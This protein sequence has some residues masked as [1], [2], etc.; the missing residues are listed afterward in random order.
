MATLS[1]YRLSRA[2]GRQISP[3][4]RRVVAPSRSAGRSARGALLA[5]AATLFAASETRADPDGPAGRSIELTF[6]TEQRPP[7]SF[8]SAAGGTIVGR[9][10]DL[11]REMTDRLGWNVAFKSEAWSRSYALAMSRPDTCVFSAARI[12]GREAAFQWVGPLDWSNFA[13]VAPADS[14]IELGSLEDA[15]PYRI[16]V[17]TQDARELMLR[18][19]GGYKLDVAT[20][21]TLN[22][23]KL[24]AGRIDLWFTDLSSMHEAQRREGIAL[25]PVLV[26]DPE[27]LYLA[28]NRATPDWAIRAMNETLVALEN[29]GARKRIQSK[30]LK[31]PL[32]GSP[33]AR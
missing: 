17:Y 3:R 20:I 28:C 30:Y 10:A 24:F 33:A 15:R 1:R 26:L 27:A 12:A 6:L 19:L 21:D 4:G 8:V 32:P 25:K 16:G 29:E 31:R 11:L 2:V 7:K 14:G 18:K 22:A 9:N 13:V 5:F 23:R